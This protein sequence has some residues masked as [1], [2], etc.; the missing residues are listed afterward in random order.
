MKSSIVSIGIPSL[1]NPIV[2]TEWNR[3]YIMIS[4]S[5]RGYSLT[6]SLCESGS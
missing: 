2:Y 3:I 6:F 5:K 1:S 4:A